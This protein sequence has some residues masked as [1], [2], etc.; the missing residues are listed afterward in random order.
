MEGVVG[1]GLLET[2][3]GGIHGLSGGGEGTAGQHL[4]LLCV[5]DFGAGVDDF[6]LGFEELPSE[7]SEL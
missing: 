4:D 3:N 2:L 5:S 1:S 6:L 7:V